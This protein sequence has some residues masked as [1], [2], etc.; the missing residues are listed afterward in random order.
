[1]KRLK[2]LKSVNEEDELEKVPER[3]KYNNIP[4]FKYNVKS[5]NKENRNYHINTELSPNPRLTI[6]NSSFLENIR[7]STIDNEGKIITNSIK[8]VSSV[9]TFLPF[10]AN[11]SKGKSNI[12]AENDMNANID[13][14]IINNR[15][16]YVIIEEE[17]EDDQI[18][19]KNNLNQSKI[20]S[21]IKVCDYDE[22]FPVLS[23]DPEIMLKKSPNKSP[24][25]MSLR[26]LSNKCLTLSSEISSIVT[27]DKFNMIIDSFVKLKICKVSLEKITMPQFRNVKMNSVINED[28]PSRNFANSEFNNKKV[29]KDNRMIIF[30]VFCLILLF[31]IIVV[32]VLFF[33][34]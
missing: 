21:Q 25:K 20:I 2:I 31:I 30:F 26:N 32:I 27:L 7:R 29:P 12:N 6:S 18:N 17:K 3:I 14:N 15:K 28:S 23:S 11:D 16:T 1:M 9:T 13:S 24:K 8:R 19:L 10:K 22:G 33:N 4:E 5:F 34:K